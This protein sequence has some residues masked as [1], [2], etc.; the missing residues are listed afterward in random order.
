MQHTLKYAKHIL[1]EISHL[2]DCGLLLLLQRRF[3]LMLTPSYLSCDLEFRSSSDLPLMS[4]FTFTTFSST[5]HPHTWS[6][7]QQMK[8]PRASFVICHFLS[9]SVHALVFSRP[10]PRLFNLLFFGFPFRF[11]SH[12]LAWSINFTHS[13]FSHPLYVNSPPYFCHFNLT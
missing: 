3:Y 2:F 4:K 10:L 12:G 7:L 13:P 1:I 8:C 6:A 9:P 5:F 11:L